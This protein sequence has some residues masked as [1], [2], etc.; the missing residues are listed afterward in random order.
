MFNRVLNAPLSRTKVVFQQNQNARRNSSLKFSKESPSNEAL[1]S[2][3]YQNLLAVGG[4]IFCKKLEK[5][6]TR[7]K[8]S[9]SSSKILNSVFEETTIKQNPE[10]TKNVCKPEKLTAEGGHSQSHSLTKS[11]THYNG[12]YLKTT[13]ER[14]VRVITV[15]ILCT[16]SFSTEKWGRLSTWYQGVKSIFQAISDSITTNWWDSSEPSESHIIE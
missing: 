5:T 9:I 12:E 2:R 3:D 11:F 16:F 10:H 1:V 8:Q 6:D 7:S 14:E 15:S 13:S 4:K